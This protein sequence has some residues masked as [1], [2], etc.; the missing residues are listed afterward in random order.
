[1]SEY[2][3]V[4]FRAIESPLNSDAIEFMQTQSSRAEVDQWRFANEYNFGSF[5][6]DCREML[7]RG[8]DLHV[9]YSSFGN[10]L[11]LCAAYD[12]NE[13]PEQTIEPPVPHGLDTMPLLLR[14]KSDGIDVS[15]LILSSSNWRRSLPPCCGLT[16]LM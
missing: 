4:E 3:W 12:G 2:Q 16:M 7:R 13:D 5:G 14:L 1:M 15:Y 11:L 10:L 6:G 9:H 8:Y